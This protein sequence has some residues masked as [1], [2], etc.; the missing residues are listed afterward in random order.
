MQ[1]ESDKKFRPGILLLSIL[2]HTALMLIFATIQFSRG[3]LIDYFSQ[4]PQAKIRALESIEQAGIVVPKP[5]IKGTSGG[6]GDDGGFFLSKQGLG[7][8]QTGLGGSGSGQ[9]TGDGDGSGNGDGDGSGSGTGSGS[10]SGQ[11]NSFLQAVAG[12]GSGTGEAFAAIADDSADIEHN[13]VSFFGNVAS[14]RKV[15]FVVDCSGSMLGFFKQVQDNLIKSINALRQ[16]YFFAIIVFHGE[17]VI[18]LQTGMLM[19]ASDANKLKAMQFIQSIPTPEGKPNAFDAVKAAI[20]YKDSIGDSPGVVYFL[21]DGF[22]YT[23]FPEKVEDYR[24]Q[25]APVVKIHTIG[26]MVNNNDAEMLRKIAQRSGGNFTLY[27]GGV[28]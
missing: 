3:K 6:G 19:R 1:L 2:L 5:L 15:C 11:G 24:K 25:M 7:L 16:D 9:G 22:D 20:H 26:F 23:D 28:N 12:S 8:L 18:E 14:S 17:E 4:S 10:G 27:S 21:T 13:T